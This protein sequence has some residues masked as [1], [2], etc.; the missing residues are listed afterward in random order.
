[1]RSPAPA[2]FHDTDASV[3]LDALRGLAAL[4]VFLGHA[5]E[6]FLRAGLR[7]AFGG[8][9]A[10]T[11]LA[12]APDEP[13]LRYHF[14]LR[15]FQHFNREWLSIGH[16]AVV[17]FFVLSGFLVGGSAL[18]SF[19]KNAFSWKH[20]FAHR[21]CRLWTV[22]WPALLL[23]LLLDSS[24]MHLLHAPPNLQALYR[25]GYRYL[26]TGTLGLPTLLANAFFLQDIVSG[27]FGSNSPLWSLSYEFWYYAF[28]PFLLFALHATQKL[29]LRLLAGLALVVMLAFTGWTIAA[30]FS[31][32]LM[33]VLVS[34]LPLRLPARWH[35][36]AIVASTLLLLALTVL[37][38][39]HHLPLFL[40]DFLA[41]MATTA[42][43][44]SLLHAR[45]VTV[46][47]IYKFCARHFSAMSFT[48]YLVHFPMLG[49]LSAWLMPVWAP[50]PLSVASLL[51]VFAI[52][53]VVF[54]ASWAMYL[55]FERNTPRIRKALTGI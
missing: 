51:K 23:G 45:G 10:A 32:W 24:A 31:I 54:A 53:L 13:M 16:Q 50:W 55:C 44:W 33:G 1:M 17:V 18:R 25:P 4:A 8:N 7:G 9:G 28:F 49:I 42:M 37:E 36:W 35:G 3:H 26:A 30:Y 11:G 21:F 27:V 2:K 38:L 19:R 52:V 15:S 46:G 5:R 48:L 39:K 14:A 41:G 12:T 29:H 20:Y 22:L 40:S 47:G 34:M 43:V 6:F